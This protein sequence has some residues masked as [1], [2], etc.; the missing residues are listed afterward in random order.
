MTT[1]LFLAV[2]TLFQPSAHA[3]QTYYICPEGYKLTADNRCYGSAPSSGMNLTSPTLGYVQPRTL[4]C[5]N[6]MVLKYS[7]AKR[8]YMCFPR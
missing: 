4:K 3:Q 1:L 6:Q 7:N 2:S 8:K 5:P